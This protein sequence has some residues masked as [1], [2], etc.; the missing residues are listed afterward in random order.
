MGS[1][2]VLTLTLAPELAADLRAAVTTG[3]YASP[4][5]VVSEALQEWRLRRLN[6][7]EAEGLRRLVREGIESGPGLEDGQVA[8]RL[9]ARFGPLGA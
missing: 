9:S 2:E 5:E 4:G 3:G 8:A 1:A 7:A 6:T